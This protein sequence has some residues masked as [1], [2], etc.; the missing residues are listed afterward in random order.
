VR[1]RPMPPVRVRRHRAIAIYPPTDQ[2]EDSLT[3]KC[4]FCLTARP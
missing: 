3:V 4:D 1:M 2:N